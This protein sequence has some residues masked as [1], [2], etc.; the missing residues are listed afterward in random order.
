MACIICKRYRKDNLETHMPT[1]LCL[2]FHGISGKGGIT[3]TSKIPLE[4]RYNLLEDLTVNQRVF[5]SYINTFYRYSAEYATPEQRIKSLYLWSE[6]TGTGKTFTASA[7]LNEF[8]LHNCLSA[9][10]NERD[11]PNIPIYFLDVNEL[12]DLYNQFNRP[13]TDSTVREEAS[14]EYYNRI[15]MAKK[16]S[17]TVFDDIGVRG[18]T[19]GFRGDLHSLINHRVTQQSPS[20]YTSNFPLSELEAVYDKRLYDRVRDLCVEVHFDGTS[21][22]GKR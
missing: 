19:E 2:L 9:W 16:A 15:K 4:Y 6:E 5:E 17:M 14:S 11:L 7:I 18:A 22:R 8:A 3:A 10:K 13:G 1:Q 21:K 12:Q 20:V